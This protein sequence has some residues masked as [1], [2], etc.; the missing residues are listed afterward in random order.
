MLPEASKRRPD[1]IS[2]APLSTHSDRT[3][4]HANPR[5]FSAKTQLQPRCAKP[6]T[7][8]TEP[9]SQNCYPLKPKMKIPCNI[10]TK[11]LPTGGV[12]WGGFRLYGFV[13]Q[14]T[15]VEFKVQGCSV[16]SLGL[17]IYNL[18]FREALHRSPTPAVTP[19]MPETSVRLKPLCKANS[20]QQHCNATSGTTT[21]QK[22]G[23][24]AL[25]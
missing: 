9:R 18:C 8:N 4:K 10:V 15:V 11:T 5:F 13:L 6:Q 19:S 21:P 1:P 22:L 2:Q 23:T 12:G 16:W 24:L 20:H 3:V 14:K 7:L 17:L 25:P